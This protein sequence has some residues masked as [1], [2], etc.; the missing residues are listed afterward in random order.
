MRRI[1]VAFLYAILA[2]ASI[3]FVYAAPFH[4]HV[5]DGTGEALKD[6]L[7]IVQPLEK[8]GEVFRVLTDE[9]GNIPI[10]DLS[11]GYYRLIVTDPYGLWETKIREFAI[12]SGPANLVVN[13]PPMPTHGYG[14]RVIVN[15]SGNPPRTLTVQFVDEEGK[16]VSDVRFLVRNEDLDFATW[17]QSDSK[18]MKEVELPSEPITLVALWNG[19]LTTKTFDD[20]FV[21]QLDRKSLVIPL[22]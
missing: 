10:R 22:K 17:Y 15:T 13:L 20:K 5:Q 9:S 12:N 6:Q 1:S 7:V 4:I 21:D 8:Y 18:G 16:P 11:P 3:P 2:C 19:N 14:D